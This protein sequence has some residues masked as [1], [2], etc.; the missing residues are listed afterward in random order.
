MIMITAFA[1]V[2][3]GGQPRQTRH[4]PTLRRG[5]DVFDDGDRKWRWA[6]QMA[7]QPR[8]PVFERIEAGENLGE[9]VG[10]GAGVLDRHGLQPV[11]ALPKLHEMIDQLDQPFFGLQDVIGDGGELND[12]AHDATLSATMRRRRDE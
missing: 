3:F 4:R 7:L 11:E 12:G 6:T 10:P 9:R 2:S 1:D 5:I 8:Q